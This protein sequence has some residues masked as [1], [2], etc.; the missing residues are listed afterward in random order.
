FATARQQAA[1]ARHVPLAVIEATAYVNTRWE[2]IAARAMDGGVGPMK[3]RPSQLADASSLS[4]RTLASITSDLAS[5][6]DAGAALLAHAHTSGTD[7]ASGQPALTATQGPVVARAI[8]AV[9]AGG[10]GRTTS[11][12]ETITLAPQSIATSGSSLPG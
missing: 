6:L 9:L 5:N 8:M 3:V 7:L 4:G 11:T 10:A 12:G 2:W 1:D